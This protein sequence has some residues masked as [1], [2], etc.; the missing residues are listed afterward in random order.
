MRGHHHFLLALPIVLLAVISVPASAVL[1]QLPQFPN[2]FYGNVTVTS[3]RRAPVG[4]VVT[5]GVRRTIGA[6]RIVP[7]PNNLAG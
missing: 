5:G 6:Q 1:A 4:M 2:T 3:G 7:G